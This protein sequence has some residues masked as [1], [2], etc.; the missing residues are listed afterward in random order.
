MYPYVF[1]HAQHS[2][3][4][5][6]LVSGHHQTYSF[7]HGFW[8]IGPMTARNNGPKLVTTVKNGVVHDGTPMRTFISIHCAH[9]RQVPRIQTSAALM[10]SSLLHDVVQ[11]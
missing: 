8:Y 9:K 7:F 3:L 1:R 5:R 10:R 2:L 4:Q 6:G 11:T